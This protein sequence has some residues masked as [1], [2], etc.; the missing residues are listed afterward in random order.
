[1]RDDGC[2]EIGGGDGDVVICGRQE[3]VPCDGHGGPCWNQADAVSQEM[4]EGREGN[5]TAHG[6]LY[7]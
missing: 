5:R 4:K 1:M 7:C 3:E 2:F 6:I